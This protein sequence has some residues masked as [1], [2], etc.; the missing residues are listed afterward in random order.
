MGKTG[1]SQSFKNRT[2]KLN[3]DTFTVHSTAQQFAIGVVDRWVV[4]R[5]I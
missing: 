1:F 5:S 3:E 2:F 4:T